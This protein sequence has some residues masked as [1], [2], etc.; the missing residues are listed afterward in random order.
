MLEQ[1]LTAQRNFY[2]DRIVMAKGNT[3][4]YLMHAIGTEAEELCDTPP[5]YMDEMTYLEQELADVFLY[6]MALADNLAKETKEE[7]QALIARIVMEKISRNILKYSAKMFS[8]GRTF[9]QAI[10]VSKDAWTRTKGNQ[11]FY[12][13]PRE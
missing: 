3:R 4:E 10:Q 5:D 12:S 8:N 1:L 6:C 11:E 9:E 2:Q 7:T 13:I